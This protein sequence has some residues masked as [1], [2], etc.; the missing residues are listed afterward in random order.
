MPSTSAPAEDLQEPVAKPIRDATA[1][2]HWLCFPADCAGAPA[3]VAPQTYCVL[4]ISARR[5]LAI[6]RIEQRRAPARE[7]ADRISA[8]VDDRALALASRERLAGEFGE[9]YGITLEFLD[10]DL[11]AESPVHWPTIISRRVLL[12]SLSA[13]RVTVAS[14]RATDLRTSALLELQHE[15]M[16]AKNAFIESLSPIT[17]DRARAADGLRPSSYNYLNG[18][19]LPIPRE[20]TPEGRVGRARQAAV[21]EDRPE[22]NDPPTIRGD[23]GRDRAQA[24]SV[25]PFLQRLITRAEY[26]P[27]CTAIDN[28]TKLVDALAAHYMVSRGIVRTLRGV[29]ARDLGRW[30]YQVDVIV[31]LLKHIPADWWPRD[32]EAWRRYIITIDTITRTTRHP[33]TTSSNMLWLYQAARRGFDLSIGGSEELVRL[34]QGIDE[35]LDMLRQAVVWKLRRADGMPKVAPG[36]RSNEI[37]GRVK[38]DLGLVK[39]ADITRRFGD[40]YRRATLRFVEEA[41]MLKGLCWPALSGRSRY[42]EIEVVPLTTPDDLMEEGIRMENC[43]A[44]YVRQCASGKCQIWSV[45][46]IDGTRLSTLET[47][48]PNSVSRMKCV[49]VAQHKG[50]NNGP[51]PRLAQDAVGLHIKA[52]EASPTALGDYLEWR[53]TIAGMPLSDRQRQALML[54]AIAALEETLPKKWALDTLVEAARADKPAAGK[55]CQA[56]LSRELIG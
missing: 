3:S 13:A 7:F 36:L 45:R 55:Y 51:V 39:L 32:P 47:H 2:L 28:G 31:A 1:C 6:A 20:K 21:P 22:S 33:I 56:R 19:Y 46:L 54:P 53:A 43:V 24:L 29:T 12:R 30:A 41:K 49:S 26:V 17:V 16:T 35:F 40:A 27:V 5:R 42:G 44:S 38:A 8:L 52:L 11:D 50:F 48:V 4:V 25:F 9:R 14:V 23:V 15:W 34:G 18:T 37:V 10:I